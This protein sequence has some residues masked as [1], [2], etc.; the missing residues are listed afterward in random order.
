MRKYLAPLLIGVLLLS[1]ISS[2]CIGEK[3]ITAS[4]T[5]PTSA[6]PTPSENS[7]VVLT[8]IGPSG[9]KSL[10]LEGLKSLPQIEGKGGYKTKMGS[11][12]GVGTYKGVSLKEL[13]ELVGG[14]SPDYNVRIVAADGYSVVV[15]YDFVLGKGIDTMD[16]NGNPTEG[17]VVPIIAYEFNGE[18]I[19]FELDGKVYP[20]QIALVGDDGCITPGNLW[21]KAVTRIEVI[22]PSYVSTGT[23]EEPK[24][25]YITVTDFRGKEVKVSQPVNRIVAIYGLA[26]QMVYLI[27]EGEKIV[28][29][30]PMVVSDSF[31]QLID[32]DAKD[33]VILAGDPTSANVEEIKKLN[34]DVVF[35][36]AW[37]DER[38][39]EQIESLGIPVI[40]LDLETV[41]S[42]LK[43]LEIIGKV[44]GKRNEVKEITKYYVNA[45]E[46]ITNKTSKFSEDQKPRVLLVMYSM[47]SKAFKAPGQEY[48]QN[49]L[50]EMA[51]G[52]SVSKELPGGW[53]VINI[54]QVA[55]WNPD[56]IIVVGYSPVYPSTKIKED[57]LNDPA[58]GQIRAVKEG[59]IYAMPNDGESWDY[60]APKW[61]LGLYWTAKV[62][63]PELFSDLDIMKEANDF[64][65]RFFGISIN[66]VSLVG[67]IS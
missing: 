5:S 20:I 53:N 18:P 43:S 41:E 32:P 21:V 37:G 14:L 46:R 23:N 47:K 22:K 25:G 4:N 11:I 34:P 26:A 12:R 57:I 54:E 51:G 8:L 31:I 2:G 30:T 49:R 40:A 58:W 27:G 10:T 28:G 3:N 15:S 16:E 59:K 9:E 55:E 39:N 24:T 35:T 33:R 6:T 48:F 50:I 60:P 62:L 64:Y 13:L 7:E 56:V 45:M 36:A 29:G 1:V 17:S 42:Y 19:T 66:D 44:L 63:H 61:I 65:E 38:V 67:D 52:I